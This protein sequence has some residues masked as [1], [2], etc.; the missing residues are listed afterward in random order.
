MIAAAE[1]TTHP[2]VESAERAL[3]TARKPAVRK[4]SAL[5][6]AIAAADDFMQGEYDRANAA[7]TKAEEAAVRWDDGLRATRQAAAAAVLVPAQLCFATDPTTDLVRMEMHYADGSVR[8]TDLRRN[9]YTPTTRAELISYCAQKGLKAK[10][11]LKVWDAWKADQAAASDAV[12]PEG[13]HA[14]QRAFEVA[15]EDWDR[16]LDTQSDLACA[17]INVRV[18]SAADAVR[19]IEA[20]GRTMGLAD[21]TEYAEHHDAQMIASSLM[22]SLR[23]MAAPVIA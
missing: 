6:R 7:H 1:H 16:A 21:P 10:S 2:A 23:R 4:L 13:W 17:I 5:D 14:A 3:A 22:K 11:L 18:T 12:M 15:E 8:I 20:Y 9:G 19:Q